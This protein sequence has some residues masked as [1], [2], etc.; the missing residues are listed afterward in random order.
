MK[1]GNGGV[2][3]NSEVLTYRGKEIDY[4]RDDVRKAAG[5]VDGYC[6]KIIAAGGDPT[7]N[8]CDEVR[9]ALDIGGFSANGEG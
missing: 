7:F 4:P 6:K 5:C 3:R 9:P 1:R 8:S 2:A